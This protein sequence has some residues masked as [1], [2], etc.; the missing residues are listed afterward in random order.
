MHGIEIYRDRPRAEW[1]R[2]NGQIVM[3]TG[4]VDISGMMDGG[5]PEECPLQMALPAGTT[6]GHMHLQVGN[7]PEA[8]QFYCDILGFDIVASMPAALFVS[9]GGYHHHIG[10]NTWHS[11]GAGRPPENSVKLNLFTVDLP[12]NDARE[13]VL[14]RLDQARVSYARAGDDVVVDDP[15]QPGRTA[16]RAQ[17][18]WSK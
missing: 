13:E 1:P 3:G 14:K 18:I 11:E 15:G 2:R 12:N 4:A 5:A 6:L 10:M 8:E 16:S 7:I 17:L 9:A